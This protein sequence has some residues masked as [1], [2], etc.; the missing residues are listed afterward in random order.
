VLGA[1]LGYA[2]GKSHDMASI[3]KSIALGRTRHRRG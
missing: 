2:T 1:S 3:R